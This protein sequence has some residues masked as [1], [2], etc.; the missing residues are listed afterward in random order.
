MKLEGIKVLDLSRF[1]PGPY[2]TRLMADHGAEVV[3]L[4]ALSGEPIRTIGTLSGGQSSYFRSTNR[5]K[6]SMGIDLK[7]PA[8]KQIFMRLA[9][10]ASVVIESFRPGVADRLGVGYDAIQRINP[11]IVYCSISA[12]GQDTSLRHLPTHDLGVQAMFGGL[13][14]GKHADG[15]PVTPGLPA[16]DTGVAMS[17]LTGILMAL[18]R[19]QTTGLGDYIDASMADAVLSW[20]PHV[21]GEPLVN[22][23]EPDLKEDRI[24]GGAAFYGVYETGDGKHIVLSGAEM[25]FVR[26]L[27][28]ALGRPDLIDLCTQ[29]G[30]RQ[31]PVIDFLRQAFRTRTRDEW[32]RWADDKNV[33]MAPVLGLQEGY[34]HPYVRERGMVEQDADGHKYLASPVRFKAEPGHSTHASPAFGEHTR[35]ILRGAGFSAAEVDSFLGDGVVA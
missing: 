3:K 17:A 5:G 4:E 28:T 32:I 20:T 24:Y 18:L 16:A 19:R 21:S 9:K 8:G 27:L 13:A 30:R 7:S 29:W 31:Q 1:L 14:L 35:D 25:E 22:G 23:A 6:K 11:G 12:F 2:V 15:T 10:D 26:N 33:C 34:S